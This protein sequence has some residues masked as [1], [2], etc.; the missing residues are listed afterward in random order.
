MQRLRL[1][2]NFYLSEGAVAGVLEGMTGMQAR[3]GGGGE[4]GLWVRRCAS[5]SP[6][7]LPPPVILTLIAFVHS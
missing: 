7:P 1:A 5:A 4:R 2:G 6:P 3:R